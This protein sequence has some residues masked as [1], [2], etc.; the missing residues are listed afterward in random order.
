MYK[1]FS[2]KNMLV[3][4]WRIYILV[5]INKLSYSE[6]ILNES[7]SYSSR[8]NIENNSNNISIEKDVCSFKDLFV[9][10][11]S[12]KN[13]QIVKLIEQEKLKRGNNNGNMVR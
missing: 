10:Q 2:Y 12:N 4:Y 9:P 7:A 13:S 8:K 1:W 5:Y 3:V 6:S 11:H